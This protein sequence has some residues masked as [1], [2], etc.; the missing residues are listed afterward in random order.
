[1]ASLY[2]AL[3]SF[4]DQIKRTQ[5][6]F[7]MENLTFAFITRSLQ[8]LDRDYRA[9]IGKCVKKWPLCS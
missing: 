6:A 8:D 2:V 1:M 3:C 4:V 7:A 9:F 5:A